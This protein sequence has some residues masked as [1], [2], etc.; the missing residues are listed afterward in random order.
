MLVRMGNKRYMQVSASA[1]P[2]TTSSGLKILIRPAICLPS[3]CPISSTISIH[4]TSSLFTAAIISSNVIG[5]SLLIR[6]DKIEFSPFFIR[7]SKIRC[8][9]DPDA[10]VSKHPFFPQ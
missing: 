10:S 6:F 1:P 4:S 7:S 2:S 3:F 9:A 8:R 5:V